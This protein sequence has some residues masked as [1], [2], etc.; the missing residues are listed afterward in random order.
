MKT[1]TCVATVV[2]SI[3]AV[4]ADEKEWTPFEATGTVFQAGGNWLPEGVPGAEDTAR[5]TT[6]GSYPVVFTGSAVNTN[7]IAGSSDGTEAI[8]DLAGNSWQIG[9]LSFQNSAVAR[10]NGGALQV[11]A[12]V[13]TLGTGRRLILEGGAAS[14]LGGLSIASGGALDI[15]GGEHACAGL[16]LINPCEE[17]FSLR[18]TAGSFVMD[19][20]ATLNLNLH[21]RLILQGGFFMTSSSRNDV[22]GDTVIEVQSNATFVSQASFIFAR[23]SR[24]T[25]A[26]NI[27]GGT[28]T[29]QQGMVFTAPTS[30]GRICS[31]G[32]VNL[33]DGLYV[34][35]TGKS[36]Y[37]GS[38]GSYHGTNC[39]AVLRQSGGR[40]EVSGG[41]GN[42]YV[43]Y[44]WATQ[45]VIDMT[46]GSAWYGGNIQVGGSS[47][48]TGVV[49]VAGGTLAAA[50]SVQLGR[51][52]EG[53]GFLFHCGG[54]LSISNKLTVGTVEDSYGCLIA[55]A[56][57]PLYVKNE[58]EVGYGVESTAELIVRSNAVCTAGSIQVYNKGVPPRIRFEACGEGLGMLVARGNLSIASGAKLEV[59]V[60][61]Y[62]GSDVWI[63][64]IDCGGSRT[65]TFA[66]ED[67]TVTGYGFVRQDVDQGIW[68]FRP[69]GTFISVL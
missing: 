31:T 44:Y 37:I 63:K 66:A 55:A 11:G 64:L 69:R 27:L 48:A 65:G 35:P 7:V 54:D 30:G 25:A 56:P 46:G 19:S 43:G 62:R 17:G 38:T 3:M 12:Q 22:Y 57:T 9:I 36:L 20:A 47:T 10:F 18:M 32:I 58:L 51:A 68:L 61:G 1:G 40:A 23:T 50:A 26:L 16:S 52:A 34:V 6:A 4:M 45:G 14:F 60:T 29:N 67:I 39:L 42:I 28:V 24:N 2:L 59:D 13:T 21:S 15:R 41:S 53:S 33:V 49:Q 8:F 5:F